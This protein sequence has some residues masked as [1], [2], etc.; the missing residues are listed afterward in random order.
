MGIHRSF[1]IYVFLVAA[2]ATD[3]VQTSMQGTVLIFILY[4]GNSSIM[5]VMLDL[6]LTCK[7]QPWQDGFCVWS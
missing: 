3:D 6:V 4:K 5:A 7:A 1:F 2:A